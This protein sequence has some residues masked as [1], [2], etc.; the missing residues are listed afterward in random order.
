MATIYSVGEFDNIISVCT[1][2]S[3]KSSPRLSATQLQQILNFIYESEMSTSE[4]GQYLLPKNWKP[5]W[6]LVCYE[7]IASVPKR[8]HVHYQKRTKLVLSSHST[9]DLI[10]VLKG[11]EQLVPQR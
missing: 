8:N 9:R 3:T 4:S 5:V 7:N 6:K 2:A 1:L 11:G 10:R